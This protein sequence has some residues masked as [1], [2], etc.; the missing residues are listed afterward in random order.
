V[1]AEEVERLAE[2][3]TEATKQIDTLIRTIQNEMNEAVAA[4]ESTTNEVVEGSMLAEEAG[5][6]L[7]QIG[8]V[9]DQLTELIQSI[10]QASQEQAQ[11]SEELA[12]SMIEI[13]QVTQQTASGTRDAAELIN[14]LAALADGLRASVSTF[15]LPSENG[16]F[17]D[18]DEETSEELAGS[19]GDLAEEMVPELSE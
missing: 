15:K 11:G 13:A 19:N 10:S 5:Q 7:S 6:A 16:D 3:S 17:V 12:R 2:R 9:S 4:M 8:T 18:S 1:V 14:N